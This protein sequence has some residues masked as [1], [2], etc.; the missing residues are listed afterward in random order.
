MTTTQPMLVAIFDDRTWAEQA[1]AE[2]ERAGFSRDQ[3]EFTGQGA[4]PAGGSSLSSR[5][6]LPGKPR[7]LVAS[8]MTW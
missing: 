3:I 5:A 1:V 6:S 8:T 2:L 7:R 4:A